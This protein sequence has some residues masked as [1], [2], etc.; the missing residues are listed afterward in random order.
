MSPLAVRCREQYNTARERDVEKAVSYYEGQ[1]VC[2][3]VSPAASDMCPLVGSD[4]VGRLNEKFKNWYY[5]R[6]YTQHMQEVQKA[7]DKIK[8]TR[9]TVELYVSE[10]CRVPQP[11]IT[12]VQSIQAR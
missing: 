6:D 5:N 10:T 2:L 7:L 9:A 8:H 12:I 1:W 3:A 4:A 11:E